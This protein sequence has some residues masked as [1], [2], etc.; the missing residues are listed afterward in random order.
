MLRCPLEASSR[1]SAGLA[2]SSFSNTG[3]KLRRRP[4]RLA[5]RKVPSPSRSGMGFGCDSK[6]RSRPRAVQ[7]RSSVTCYEATRKG[8]VVQP[9][10]ETTVTALLPIATK[11]S[12]QIP[13]FALVVL[14]ALTHGLSGLTMN[15]TGVTIEALS[16]T[17]QTSVQSIGVCV[18]FT[19]LGNLVGIACAHWLSRLCESSFC[20]LA[21]AMM[22]QAL[23][24]SLVPCANNVSTLS[25]VYGCPP[26]FP[27]IFQI[28]LLVDSRRKRSML[29]Y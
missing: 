29:L 19:G 17:A 1:G 9:Q 24:L 27:D 10:P 16:H 6:T 12:I 8:E 11:P 25:C 28:D 7:T 20:L 3:R 13:K 18:S 22:L 5:Q 15:M 4:N 2:P 14:T 21:F 26:S 23:A